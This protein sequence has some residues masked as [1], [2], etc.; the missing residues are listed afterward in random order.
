MKNHKHLKANG[1]E[2]LPEV[3]EVVLVFTGNSKVS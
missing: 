1:T 2:K 3:Y